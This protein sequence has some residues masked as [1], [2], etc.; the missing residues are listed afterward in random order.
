MSED[1]V[2]ALGQEENERAELVDALGNL[3]TQGDTGTSDRL[4][5]FGLQPIELARDP[6]ADA[7]SQTV[8][9]KKKASG[10]AI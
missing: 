9:T 10:F 4:A 8:R 1:R 7:I 5:A 6:D 3:S 2:A